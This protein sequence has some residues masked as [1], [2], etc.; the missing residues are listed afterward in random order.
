MTWWEGTSK[1]ASCILVCSDNENHQFSC[2]RKCWSRRTSQRS[3]TPFCVFSFPVDLDDVFQTSAWP[4]SSKLWPALCTVNT[5]GKHTLNSRFWWW[6][7]VFDVR[8]LDSWCILGR[9][10][11]STG[12]GVTWRDSCEPITASADACHVNDA[13]QH[14]LFLFLFVHSV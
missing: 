7:F 11:S 1:S 9:R 2:R 10:R 5:V 12:R 13:A 6:W 4:Q 3:Q 14:V 8:P